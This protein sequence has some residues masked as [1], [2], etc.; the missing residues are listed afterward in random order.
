MFDWIKNRLQKEA[1]YAVYDNRRVGFV[2][3]KPNVWRVVF[4]DQR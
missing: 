1:R 2:P 3:E 4:V